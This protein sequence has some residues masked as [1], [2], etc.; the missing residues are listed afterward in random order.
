MC[1]LLLSRGPIL[2][3]DGDNLAGIVHPLQ[4]IRQGFLFILHQRL[5]LV[6]ILLSYALSFF[7]SSYMQLMPAFAAMLEV[8]EKGFG[9]L[10]SFVGL[11]VLVFGVLVA[12]GAAAEAPTV[13]L[14]F[15]GVC[16]VLAIWRMFRVV[17]ALAV[18]ANT[19]LEVRRTGSA[20]R[21]RLED[22]FQRLLRSIKG[23]TT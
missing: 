9:Y 19:G 22:E 7:A 20:R 17:H 8:D 3:G 6:L 5:F 11:G 21:A 16:L 13:G 10:L 15:V 1:S 4:Q 12:M 23:S 2:A 18:P 14:S